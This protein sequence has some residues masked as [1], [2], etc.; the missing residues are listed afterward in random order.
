[1]DG[2][3]VE[4]DGAGAAVAVVAA[5]LDGKPAEL[6]QEGAQALARRGIFREGLAVDVLAHGFLLMTIVSFPAQKAKHHGPRERLRHWTEMLRF[7]QHD[8]ER[9]MAQA[10]ASSL[11]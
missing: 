9:A 7:A 3:A 2:L 11:R 6:A 10:A 5:F 4:P 8:T 1:M